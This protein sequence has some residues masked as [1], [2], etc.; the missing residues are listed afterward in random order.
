[1]YKTYPSLYTN[2][3]LM[4][5]LNN[6]K[7]SF[8]NKN[9][10]RVVFHSYSNLNKKIGKEPLGNNVDYKKKKCSIYI[11]ICINIISVL[12]NKVQLYI[13]SKISNTYYF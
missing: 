5:K 2:E 9:M 11:E 6:T 8:K 4:I 13:S 1:M 3:S 10:K 7:Q 12:P